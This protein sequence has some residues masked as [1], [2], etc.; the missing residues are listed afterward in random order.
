[1]NVLRLVLLL[2]IVQTFVVP[3]QAQKREN[4]MGFWTFGTNADWV[5]C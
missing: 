5:A 1:M 4:H 2:M 3:V